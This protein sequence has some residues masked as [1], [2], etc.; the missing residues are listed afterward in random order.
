M[1]CVLTLAF[2]QCGVS[3]IW[4]KQMLIDLT[5]DFLGRTHLGDIGLVKDI[6][7]GRLMPVAGSKFGGSLILGSYPIVL[8]RF[9]FFLVI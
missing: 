4:E 1:V 5:I 7:E 6:F 2:S 8:N 9:L 3:R